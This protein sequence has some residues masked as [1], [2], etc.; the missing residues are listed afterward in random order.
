L[1]AS[2]LAGIAAGLALIAP[3]PL[4]VARTG[5]KPPTL[6]WTACRQQPG[7][8][9]ATARVPLDYRHPQATKIRLAVIMHRATDR[10]RRIGP[11]FFNP[12]GPGVAKASFPK[13]FPFFPAQIRARFDVITWDPRG[14]GES[15]G[16]RCFG[17]QTAEDRFL[18]G[19]GKPTE[20]FPVGVA[21]MSRWVARYAEFGRRCKERAGELL[22]HMSTAESARDMD[23]LRRAIG[24]RQLTYLGVSYGTFLG[25]TYANLFP[26]LVRAMVLDGNLNP[27]AWATRARGSFPGGGGTFLPTFLRQSSADGARA[28][29]NAFLD[30]C[31]RQPRALCAFSAG[32][33]AA[34]RTKYDQL[35][36]RLRAHPPAGGPTYAEFVSQVINGLYIT[37]LWGQ[38]ATRMQKVWTS[39]AST[40]PLLTPAVASAV[41]SPSPYVSVGQTQG[42]ICADS[43]NPRPSAFSRIDAYAF[44]RAGPVSGYWTWVA[45]PCA[46]W[47]VKAPARYTGPW[48]RWTANPVLVMNTTYD[49]ATP[50]SNAVAM[51]RQL[52]RGRLLTV[53]GYGHTALLSPSPCA[54]RYET[55]YLI[56]QVLPPRGTRCPGEQPFQ[57]PTRH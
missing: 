37:E 5:S 46:T 41:G 52:A 9:C 12:G 54:I 15:T 49:P 33:P 30:L 25:A 44:D 27:A 55:R 36:A 24:A 3:A 21:E 29:V 45:E 57:R 1:I 26:R 38:L 16:V 8:E 50:Y 56:S 13:I 7:F 40:S 11:L 53:D 31:G 43:P 4:A 20:T 35:L 2:A 6:R 32:S 23:L 51:A 18:S 48:N 34:T 39:A 47:P 19:V 10:A 14:I 28:T 22:A 42:I 17:S